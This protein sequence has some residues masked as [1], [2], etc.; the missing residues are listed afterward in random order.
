MKIYRIADS[1]SL[2][3]T[4]SSLIAMT[5]ACYPLTSIVSQEEKCMDESNDRSL[6]RV[7]ISL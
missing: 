2:A 3:A 1:F 6:W 7:E 5:V 4:E